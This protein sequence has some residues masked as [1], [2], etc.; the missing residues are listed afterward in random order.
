MGLALYIATRPDA[1]CLSAL[2]GRLQTQLKLTEPLQV[3]ENVEVIQRQDK[4]TIYTFILN[5]SSTTQQIALP[6]SMCNVLTQQSHE[7]DIVLAAR[8][9]AIL[10]PLPIHTI[11][12]E[13]SHSR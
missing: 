11:L 4:H 7:H 13:E 12:N 9:C 1:A 3:P 6:Q 8:D 2:L 5:H 10:R